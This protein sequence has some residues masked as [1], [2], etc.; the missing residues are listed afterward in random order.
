MGSSLSPEAAWG[1]RWFLGIGTSFVVGSACLD[2]KEGCIPGQVGFAVLEKKFAAKIEQESG[3][4]AKPLK[5]LA[6]DEARFGLI[7]WHRRGYCPKGFRPP[8]V[9]RRS[10]E[11]T[12]LYAAVE[13]TTGES[14]CLYLPGMDDG[15]LQIF[16]GEL[17]KAYPENHLLSTSK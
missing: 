14:F 11:W 10:Y 2:P 17:S 4:H 7:S 6:F 8:Y 16:L 5:V 1:R 12:Y 9:V 13:P 15:C 3:R